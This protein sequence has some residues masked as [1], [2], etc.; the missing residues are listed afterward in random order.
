M[1]V[2]YYMSSSGSYR[3]VYVEANAS[4]GSGNYVEYYIKVYFNGVLVAEGAKNEIIVTVANGTYTA[5]VYVKDSN[6]NEAT[7]TTSMTLSGY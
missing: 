7:H 1:G 2:G 6:G 4:G 5:E 3:G